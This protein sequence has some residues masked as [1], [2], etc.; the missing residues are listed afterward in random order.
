[1]EGKR[2][3][4]AAEVKKYIV[5]KHATII[6]PLRIIKNGVWG[7]CHGSSRRSYRENIRGAR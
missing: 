3:I 6:T 2:E 7:R 4:R 1:M 5:F